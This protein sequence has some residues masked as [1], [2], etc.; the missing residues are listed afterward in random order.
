MA[1]TATLSMAITG[2]SLMDPSRV[3]SLSHMAHDQ[4][5]AIPQLFL[6]RC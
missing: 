6:V 5:Q 1:Q 2:M 3:L 4:N